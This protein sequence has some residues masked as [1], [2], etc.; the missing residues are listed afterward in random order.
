MVNFVHFLDLDDDL[1]LLT[2]EDRSSERTI[3]DVPIDMED[4]MDSSKD[5]AVCSLA[6]VGGKES[7]SDENSERICIAEHYKPTTKDISDS[8]E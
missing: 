2:Q 6:R 4:L 1:S 5:S 3:N 8:D 7:D